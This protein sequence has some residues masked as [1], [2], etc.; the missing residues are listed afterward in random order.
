MGWDLPCSYIYLKLFQFIKFFQSNKAI[1]FSYF[2]WFFT[3]LA[4]LSPDAHVLGTSI[5]RSTT[6]YIRTAAATEGISRRIGCQLAKGICR[7]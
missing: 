5:H 1:Y 4:G 3:L 2:F 7:G 6:E